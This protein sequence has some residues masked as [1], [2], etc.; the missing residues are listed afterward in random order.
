MRYAS[1]VMDVFI[2]RLAFGAEGS[3]AIPQLGYASA[4]AVF[5]G[6]T[7]IVFTVLQ[8]WSARKAH[9]LRLELTTKGGR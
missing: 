1:E 5:F 6:L 8:A 2:Y 9:S 4:A 7:V 3:G